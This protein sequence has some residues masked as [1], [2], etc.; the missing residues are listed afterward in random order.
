[1]LS[2]T[3]FILASHVIYDLSRWFVSLANLHILSTFDYW[4]QL[5]NDK[6]LLRSLFHHE[7]RRQ[8]RVFSQLGSSKG[9]EQSSK[10]RLSIQNEEI[11]FA[12]CERFQD[13]MAFF[14]ILLCF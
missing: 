7:N 6:Y 10:Q 1:M 11:R 3:W 9:D 8:Q 5:Q 4:F 12:D 14:N 13:F 2:T